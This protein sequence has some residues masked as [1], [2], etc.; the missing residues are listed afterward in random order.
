MGTARKKE[1]RA[2]SSRLAKARKLRGIKTNKKQYGDEREERGGGGGGGS[3]NGTPTER[4][5]C[6]LILLLGTWHA[7]KLSLK[8]FGSRFNEI[9]SFFFISEESSAETL[10]PVWG[11]VGARDF[12]WT[13]GVKC[14]QEISRRLI[15]PVSL[16]C[17]LVRCGCGLR[18]PQLQVQ[19]RESLHLSRVASFRFVFVT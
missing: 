17:A 15:R 3:T 16:E 18:V 6:I 14:G 4:Y 10:K 1:R 8:F 2:L 7:R 5:F 12:P 13:F 19:C 11:Q 9:K